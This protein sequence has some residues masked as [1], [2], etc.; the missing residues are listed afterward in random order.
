MQRF[1]TFVGALRYEFR[2]QI[3][4]RSVWITFI[5]L[6]LFFIVFHQPSLKHTP[7]LTC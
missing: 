3:H 6:G 5:A 4:R 2:M 1:D 7:I